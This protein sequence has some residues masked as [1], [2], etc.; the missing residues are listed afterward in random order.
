MPKNFKRKRLLYSAL[1]FALAWTSF[2]LI[3]AMIERGILGSSSHYPGTKNPYNFTDN[4]LY[5]PAF[6]FIIGFIQGWLEFTLLK[7]WLRSRPIIIRILAKT[8]FY[9]IFIVFFMVMMSFII[10][11][12][13]LGLSPFDLKV[14]RTVGIFFRDFAFWSIIIYIYVVLNVTLLFYE[15]SH[16]LGQTT[17]KNLVLG[18][19]TRPFEESRIFMFLDMKSSTKIAE[20]I[21]HEA[22]FN[23]LK[24]V[25]SDMTQAIE[26]NAGE[27]YQYIGDEIVISWSETTGIKDNRCLQCFIDILNQFERKQSSY[28]QKYQVA[29]VFKAGLH[30]GTVATGK[31]GIL[32]KNIIYTGDVLNTTAR[33]QE[34]S[35]KLKVYVLFSEDLKRKLNIPES[36][37]VVPHGQFEL[38]GRNQPIELYSLTIPARM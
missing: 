38:R 3:Y 37:S 5:V 30:L 25:F 2:A 4:V 13:A 10:N 24:D 35:K 6:S 16:Y 19:Y 34:L 21:G 14:I 17:F 11:S 33:I 9:V 26:H 7:N 18:K 36:F 32:K 31:I 15:T 1:T 22:Y 20:Q 8:L 28:L 23:L 27:V 12:R 29:P